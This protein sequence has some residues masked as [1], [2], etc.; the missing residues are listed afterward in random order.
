MIG[1]YINNVAEVIDVGAK[2]TAAPLY[3]KPDWPAQ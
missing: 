1:Q 2:R 3:P